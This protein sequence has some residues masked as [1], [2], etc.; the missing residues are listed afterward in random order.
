MGISKNGLRF[1]IIAKKTGVDF[2]KTAMIGRQTIR[3]PFAHFKAVINDEASINISESNL[4]HIYDHH[5]AE[6]LFELL[7][8][9]EVHSFDFSDY[10]KA[11]HT[12]DF[13]KPISDDFKNKY[14]LVIDGGSLE[15]IFNFPVA[16]QNCMEMVKV[17]GHFI[18]M[19]PSNN[20]LGHGFY[21]FS[22]E[23][24]YRILNDEN[25]FEVQ[26]MLMYE[27]R[28]SRKW[29]SVKDP[30]V[31]KSRVVLVNDKPVILQFI[32]KRNCIKTI[33]S[34][35]PQQSDYQVEWTKKKESFQKKDSFLSKVK[36]FI[37]ITF[38][39]TI[40]VKLNSGFHSSYY[41]PIDPIALL[42]SNYFKK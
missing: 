22:P 8:A 32:A 39:T 23:L 6:P 9:R 25:G 1:L 40:K 12:H 7:G 27:N 14:S 41:Q 30:D 38:K 11:T 26:K 17:D 13:N 42:K 4:K 19:T 37:P 2:S 36:S 5:Y 31:V 21:Q 10:E 29:M 24:F 16:V 34:K 18:G 33:F 20:Y 15:H 35:T 28:Y 3:M